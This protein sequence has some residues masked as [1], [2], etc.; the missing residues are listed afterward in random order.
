M[1]VSRVTFPNSDRRFDVCVWTHLDPFKRDDDETDAIVDAVSAIGRALS[2][3]A[4]LAPDPVGEGGGALARRI[5]VALI[6]PVAKWH[7]QASA[8]LPPTRFTEGR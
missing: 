7:R 2:L 8:P 3:A 1:P 5:A 4:S 6:G